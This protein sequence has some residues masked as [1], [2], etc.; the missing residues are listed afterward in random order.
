MQKRIA[1]PVH[2]GRVSPVFDAAR[3][4]VL[5]DVADGG[6]VGREEQP[7][8]AVF[9]ARRA[10]WLA[11]QRTDV[12]ICGAISM[13][14]AQMVQGHGI[15]LVPW[16]AGPLED[17]IRGFMDNGLQHAQFAMPGCLGRGRR[18]RRGGRRRM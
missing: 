6:P 16:V 17:V 14:L 2:N 15:Q 3:R 11:E 10:R 4:I 9:P 7:I 5:V 1:I 8:E 12:L 18:H 13:P